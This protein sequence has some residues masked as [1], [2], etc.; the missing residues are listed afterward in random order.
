MLAAGS[1]GGYC[2]SQPS[3]SSVGQIPRAAARLLGAASPAPQG[4][5]QGWLQGKIILTEFLGRPSMARESSA[6]RRGAVTAGSHPGEKPKAPIPASIQAGHPGPASPEALGRGSLLE[7][8][9]KKWF[10]FSRATPP[11]PRRSCARARTHTAF[12]KQTD[13]TFHCHLLL[14]SS[15]ER[16]GG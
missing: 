12:A 4:C 14:G 13:Y 3:S 8:A 15:E 10:P 7:K 6:E 11:A 16:Q 9:L 5:S 1:T 2:W